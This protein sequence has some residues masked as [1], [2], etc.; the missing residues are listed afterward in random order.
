[1]IVFEDLPCMSHQF[2]VGGMVDSFNAFNLDAELRVVRVN[3][4]YKFGFRV[5]RACDQ[6]GLGVGQAF[7]DAMI[8][9]LIFRSVSRTDRVGF[10]VQMLR[11]IVRMDYETLKPLAIKVEN[12]RFTMI[13]PDN[14]VI[15]AGHD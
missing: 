10:V 1:M 2:A 9:L 6:N 5:R 11:W 14:G 15:F 3:V 7:N 12:S 13:D 4:F 8:V